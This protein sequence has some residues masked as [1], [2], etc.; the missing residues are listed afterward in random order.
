MTMTIA[1]PTPNQ[2]KAMTK[3]QLR[4]GLTKALKLTEESLRVAAAYWVELQNRGVDLVIGHWPYRAPPI[5]DFR[6]SHVH[7]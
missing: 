4:A 5:R 2:L 7:L 6:L 3:E 1:M